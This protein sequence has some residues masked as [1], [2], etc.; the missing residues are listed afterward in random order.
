MADKVTYLIGAGASAK[1]LPV[2]SGMADKLIEF[3]KKVQSD[4]AFVFENDKLKIG[5][6]NVT[7]NEIKEKLCD[8]LNYVI[9]GTKEHASIDTFAKKLFLSGNDEGLIE[10]KAVLSC[11]FTY[12]QTKPLFDRRYDTFFAS[13]LRSNRQEF[14]ENLRVLSWNYDS[15][16]EIAY[17]GFTAYNS[18]HEIQTRLNLVPNDTVLH[19]GKN[20]EFSSN[21][22][23][24]F[25]LNGTAGMLNTSNAHIVHMLDRVPEEMNLQAID[26]IIR[27][28][29]YMTLQEN[30]NSL[31]TFAWE[32]NSIASQVIERAVESTKDT[33]VLV[34][35]GYSFPFF[36]RDVDR[37]IIRAMESLKTIYFQA[38]PEHLEENMTRFQAIKQGIEKV[39]VKDTAQFFLPPEL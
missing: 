17:E 36:N 27:W 22:F 25:K 23:A 11:F 7:R 28:Y 35:I 19:L 5:K 37:K 26:A 3:S 33:T 38:L 24:I 32:S 21:E 39:A 1:A 15:Q 34:C 18:F 31:L 4:K 6:H 29:G 13:I 16:F 20:I 8:A 2:I 30:L 10:L 9:K 14:P 12:L